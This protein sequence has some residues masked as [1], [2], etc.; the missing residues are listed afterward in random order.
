MGQYDNIINVIITII[1]VLFSAGAWQFYERKIKL[2]TKLETLDRTDQ[3]MYRDDLR[4]RVKRLEQLLVSG[5]EE[6]DT[7]HNQILSLT[8]EV[9]ALHVKVDFLEKENSRLK[10]K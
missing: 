9:S 10:N 7:M 1:T 8:K 3:N 2:K 4:E 6:K 5:A